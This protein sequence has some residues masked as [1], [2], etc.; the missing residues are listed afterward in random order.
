MIRKLSYCLKVTMFRIAIVWR[1]RY[2]RRPCCC[3]GHMGTD[4]FQFQDLNQDD[5]ETEFQQKLA[6]RRDRI[7]RQI[8]KRQKNGDFDFGLYKSSLQPQEEME[9]YLEFHRKKRENW[10]D[11]E[12]ERWF[13]ELNK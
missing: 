6:C 9:F 12:F 11:S 10:L 2:R 3:H 13:E 5:L 1:Q 4:S 8:L 7:E